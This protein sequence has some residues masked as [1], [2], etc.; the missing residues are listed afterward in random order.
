MP[1]FVSLR[2][3]CLRGCSCA[4]SCG[5]PLRPATAPGGGLLGR[6]V[7][8][9][10]GLFASPVKVSP[11]PSKEA[12]EVLVL[13]SPKSPTEVRIQGGEGGGKR[14]GGGGS[15]GGVPDGG[16]PDGGVLDDSARPSTAPAQ[17]GGGRSAS[18]GAAR[19]GPGAIAA[20]FAAGAAE[21]RTVPQR[22]AEKELSEVADLCVS[23]VTVNAPNALARRVVV[24]AAAW[25]VSAAFYPFC[26]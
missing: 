14:G 26:L 1:P 3:L 13:P 20:L 12:P 6:A 9:L 8:S 21:T 18:V 11:K 2:V 17:L 19:S 22:A 10:G 25:G 4:G 24:T 15:A 23:P 16:I 7:F 5:D